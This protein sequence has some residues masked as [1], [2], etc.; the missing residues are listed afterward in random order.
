[1]V[2]FRCRTCGREGELDFGL[3]DGYFW[4]SKEC[5]SEFTQVV[6]HLAEGGD[7]AEIGVDRDSRLF[8]EALM[9]IQRL[10]RAEMIYRRDTRERDWQR[11]RPQPMRG[12]YPC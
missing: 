2:T 12:L 9:E 10:R 7:P 8:S 1:M 4:C 3:P 5:Y 6:D 11:S